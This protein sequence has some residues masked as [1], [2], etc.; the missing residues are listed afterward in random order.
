MKINGENKNFKG[1]ENK[2]LL[3]YL[4]DDLGIIT[5]KSGCTGQGSC[6]SCTVQIN[7][8]A[9][10]ACAT[11]MKK[12]ESAEILTPDALSQQEKEV[13]SHAFVKKGGVQCG[14]CIPGIVMRAKTLL[15]ENIKPNRKDIVKILNKHTCRCT[16]YKKIIDSI[17]Y[18]AEIL[19]DKTDS[20]SYT[21]FRFQSTMTAVLSGRIGERLAKYD[22][23]HKVLGT[24]PFVADLSE[25]GMLF[26][27]L[28]FSEYPRA[29]LLSIDMTQALKLDG[30]ERIF[31]A[32][33]IPGKR[34]TGLIINDWP[35]M[36]DI[37][38]QT[39]YVGDVICG[40]VAKS[41]ELARKAVRLIK[42]DYEILEPVLNTSEALK[43]N[44]HQIHESSNILDTCEL[45][46]GDI[47]KQKTKTKYKA[48]G[49][50]KSQAIEHAFLEP[51]CT[52]AKPWG[53]GIEVFSQGQGAYED[54]RQ[55]A[56]LLGLQK[57]DVKVVQVASGGGFG[58]KEDLTTQG[59]AALFSYLLKK[60]VRVSLTRDES[61][62]MHP[63]R[64]PFDMN[65]EIGC[66]KNGLLTY[67]ISDIVSDTGAYASVGMK[68]VER[69][70]GHASG[71][72]FVPA[73]EVRGKTVYTN[74]IPNGAMRGFGVNQATFAVE[75]LIDN[76]CEQGNFDRWQF[77]FDNALDIGKQTATGQ[78]INAAAGLKDCLLAVKKE[79]Y[80]AKYAGLACGLKNTGIGNG[81]ADVGQ[82]K[83]V[84]ESEDC[85]VVHHGWTEMG[86]GVH[87]MAQQ[88]LS[89]ETGID[90]GK[91]K[92]CVE[93]NEEAEC[94]MTTA[95][96]ATSLVG[97]G[98]IDAAKELKQDLKTKRLNDLVGKSY[99]GKWSFNDSTKPEL[100]S[101]KK[102]I[103]HYSYS[104]AAQ[105]VTLDDKGKLLKV[106]AAHDA[107]KVI[108]PTLF[109]GQIEGAVHMGLGYAIRENFETIGGRPK[110][111]KLSSC[112]ILKASH[113]PEV[114]VIAIE[115]NDPNGPHGAKGVGEIGLVPT[116]G[117]VANALYQFDKK[118]RYCLPLKEKCLIS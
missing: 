49:K 52:L 86:Q 82:A 77:R 19:R 13:Y 106:T 88:F 73:I 66:D 36:V 113:M 79:F 2:K 87:T 92:V 69:G 112:Q 43:T 30:I 17:E 42:V 91:I 45:A 8:Q 34:H 63:K 97:H 68:V 39:R 105:L 62:I 81:M 72:Y 67:L 75:S 3:D 94:G 110:S 108:N 102:S 9:K 48:T 40:V 95:S 65:Y 58:G 16:G 116:A 85:V 64:H 96:R 111:T 90:A 27:A 14:F 6:G 28:K 98:V 41:K 80:K 7:G 78:T 33:D 47:L 109:E 11:L 74:N 15:D 114:E 55:I 51:E 10:L 12:L 89:E 23:H 100:Y 71:A 53:S 83:I 35:L 46:R 29:K 93:T 38:E 76:L 18:A 104:Y 32:K 54:R 84:I 22:S 31:S 21:A 70:V 5:V 59:H 25:P 37:G 50:F 44:A 60:P 115:A 101:K 103:T 107:G 26:G 118:P 57:S 4:R 117:A 20:Y 99:F 61:M 1:P 56:L 24:S